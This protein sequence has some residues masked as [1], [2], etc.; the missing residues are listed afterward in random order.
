MASVYHI[1]G[2]HLQFLDGIDMLRV[3]NRLN[4]RPDDGNDCHMS[5]GAKVIC[6]YIRMPQQSC[7]GEACCNGCELVAYSN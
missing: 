5:V 2:E 7:Y 1:F 6:W 3:M 4:V